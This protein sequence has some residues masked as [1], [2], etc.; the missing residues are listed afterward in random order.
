[1][2][3][4]Q[5][6]RKKYLKSL[7]KRRKKAED[8]ERKVNPQRSFWVQYSREIFII[9][10]IFAL[11]FLVYVLTGQLKNDPELAAITTT[12][13]EE[14]QRDFDYQ[15]PDGYQLFV[16][17][18]NKLFPLKIGTL[19]PTL[20]ID[21]KQAFLQKPE[22]PGDGLLR[23]K[24]PEIRFKGD[25][26]IHHLGFAVDRRPKSA[27]QTQLA[28]YGDMSLVFLGEDERGLLLLLGLRLREEP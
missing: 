23:V 28:H 7:D 14:M 11:A 15:F 6:R 27:V 4:R 21:W 12:I 13:T 3:I 8:F 2:G 24:F 1:M 25:T 9:I 17:R 20:Y 5:Q 16:I 10:C 22:S 19:P 26:S 18:E